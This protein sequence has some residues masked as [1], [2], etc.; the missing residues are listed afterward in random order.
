MLDD[1]VRYSNLL[2]QD[3]TVTNFG[4]GNTSV[5]TTEIDP[6]TGEPARVLWVKGSGGDLGTARPESFASLY[7]DKVCA[8]ERRYREDGLHEDE[9]VPLLPLCAFGG[10]PAAPSIDTPLHAFAPAAAVSHVHPDAVIAIAAAED[11]ERLANEVWGGRLGFLPWKRPGFELG[12][13]LR[14]LI[15][16]SP[17]IQGALLASHGLICWGDTWEEAY[18][19]TRELIADAEHFLAARERDH[20]FGAVVATEGW[21][22]LAELLPRLR[23]RAAHEGHRLI[24]H[25]DAS[26]EVL[27]FLGREK[28]PHLARLGTSCPDHFLRTK[29]RPLVLR[30]SDDLDDAFARFRREYAEYYDRHRDEGTPPMRNPNP[31]VLLLPGLGLVAFGKSPHEARVTASFYRNAIRVMRGAEAVSRY[32]ALPEAEAFGI[33]YWSLEEAKLRRQP[34]EREFARQIVLILGAG[35]GIGRAVA[36][37]LLDLGACVAVADLQECLVRETVEA[38]GGGPNVMGTALDCTDRGSVRRAVEEVVLRFGGLDVL[39]DLAGLFVPPDKEGRISDDDWRR[40]FDV[41]VLGSAIAAEE[42]ARVMRRQGTPGSIVLTGSAN[43]VV[44]KRGSLA[45]DVSKAALNHLVRELAIEL[46]PCVRVN[47]VAPATVVRGSQMFPRERVIA[48]LAKYDIPFNPEAPTEALMEKLS[49]F[50]ASRTLLKQA[51]AP[52]AVAEAA[53]LL[54]SDRLP[55]TTGHIIPVD[56][57]LA[58]GFLR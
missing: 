9:I 29:I 24:A 48:S 35:P 57:G 6:L 1:L 42:A 25:F 40:T 8:L 36:T 47:A 10:N 19:V 43:A 45:Y 21:P 18:A 50:Y 28:M 11:A 5:K 39:I 58:E 12:L 32:T 46:A 49:A 13:M 3:A 56:A 33:E 31:S 30:P 34:P 38:V 17:A 26:D 52:E 7:L 22:P 54:A 37:R 20:P 14:D 51:V 44:A 23:G 16:R 55:Q 41:N 4:G 15:A 53:I 27:D 2:G